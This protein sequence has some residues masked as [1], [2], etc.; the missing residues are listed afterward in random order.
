MDDSASVEVVLPQNK[1]HA[2]SDTRVTPTTGEFVLRDGLALGSLISRISEY[3][4]T[5]GIPGLSNTLSRQEKKKKVTV[6]H[7]DVLVP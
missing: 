2:P 7:D 3:L 1:A 5:D 6:S 4:F